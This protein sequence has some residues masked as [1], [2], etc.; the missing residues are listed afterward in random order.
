M[1]KNPDRRLVLLAINSCPRVVLCASEDPWQ[2]NLEWVK[3][4]S[5]HTDG[6]EV[7]IG[8]EVVFHV[9]GHSPKCIMYIGA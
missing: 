4:C 6:L 8:L 5:N 3:V 2:G 7:D 1:K 9:Q